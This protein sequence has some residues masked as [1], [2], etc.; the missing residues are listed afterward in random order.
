M[1]SS[2]SQI[3][4]KEPLKVL[5]S[6]S[7]RGTKFISVYNF[8]AQDHSLFGNQC[9]LNLEVMAVRDIKLR[10]RLSQNILLSPGQ[11][12]MQVNAI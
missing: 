10:S 9:I 7:I 2:N 12:D 11:T 8:P 1:T 4:T 6:S 3:Q 5:S